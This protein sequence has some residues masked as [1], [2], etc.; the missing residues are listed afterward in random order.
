MTMNQLR[1][2]VGFVLAIGTLA[3]IYAF[4]EEGLR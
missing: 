3:L 2:A 1:H 4:I